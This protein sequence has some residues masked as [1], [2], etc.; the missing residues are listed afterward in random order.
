MSNPNSMF[1]SNHN[2]SAIAAA[3]LLVALTTVYNIGSELGQSLVSQAI[4]CCSK[5]NDSVSTLQDIGIHGRIEH[6]ASLVHDDIVP[7]EAFS[8][9]IVNSTLLAELVDGKDVLTLTDYA[10]ARKRRE[11]LLTTPLSAAQASLA[12]K[13]PA[14]SLLAF[15]N[16]SAIST[17][18]IR[19][20]MGEERLPD[21]F[22]PPAE[23]VTSEQVGVIG[24]E[25]CRLMTTLD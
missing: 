8:S 21:G 7:G 12:C 6:D 5:S 20:W 13:E 17:D 1:Y 24:A 18:N 23:A 15:G 16:A 22:Q 10:A 14:L 19:V 25:V 2:G 3:D 9:D 4:G 11:A